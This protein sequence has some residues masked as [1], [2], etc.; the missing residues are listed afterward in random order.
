MKPSKGIAVALYIFADADC[1]FAESNG[2]H[3]NVVSKKVNASDLF[4]I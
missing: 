2:V 4:P 1:D 3:N